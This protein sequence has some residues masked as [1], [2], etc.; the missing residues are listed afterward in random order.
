MRRLR[1][2]DDGAVAVLVALL[3]VVLFG[4]GALVVDVGALYFE[5][6]QLQ[7]GADAASLAIAQACAAG[8]CGPYDADAE[9]FADGN[10]LDGAARVEPGEVC[11]TISVGLPACAEPPTTLVGSGYVQVTTRTEQADGTTLVPPFLAR[12]LVPGYQGTDASARATAA[13]GAAG[14]VNAELAITFSQCEYEKLTKDANGKTVY[15]S[16]PY[17]P[18]LERII[19]FHDT[20]E[21]SSCPAGPSGADLPGGFGWLDEDG[22]TATITNGWAQDDT[23]A[24]AS[25]DCKAALEALV[26]QTLLI[27]IF[28]ETNG[29]TGSNGQYRIWSFVGFVLTGWRFPGTSHASSYLPGIPCSG[30]QTCI[31]GFFV[32]A[33]A[34]S[35]GPISSGSDQGVRVVQ[36]IS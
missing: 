13:W 14:G 31:S 26:G 4:F 30:S 5:R 16:S 10:A 27:P 23:G 6:R 33:V 29:L 12:I 24:S 32:E 17:D 28:D 21:A 1:G 9:V 22:C 2:D 18:A 35:G 34:S 7:V 36:L 20:T 15:A 3:S 19:Y 8:D 25:K 11:G